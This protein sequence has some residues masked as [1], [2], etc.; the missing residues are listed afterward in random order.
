MSQP[1]FTLESPAFENGAGIPVKYTCDGE[2]VSPQL[3]WKNPP[4]GTRSYTLVVDDPDAPDGTFTHWIVYDLPAQLTSLPEGASG[5]GTSGRND[6]QE[7]GFGGPCPPP[8]HG[9]H[10]YFFRLYALDVESLGLAD[11]VGRQELDA[12]IDGHVVGTAE[13]MGRFERR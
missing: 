12:A 3:D 2:D 9:E 8:N 10:R 5:P 6:F 4:E 13:L 1:G 11:N 7:S